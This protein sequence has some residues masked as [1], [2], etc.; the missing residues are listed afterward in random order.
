VTDNAGPWFLHW[1]VSPVILS[2]KRGAELPHS[3][4]DW[5]LELYVFWFSR[6]GHEHQPTISGM[7]IVFVEDFDNIPA[8]VPVPG[9]CLA[10][11]HEFPLMTL[12]QLLGIISVHDMIP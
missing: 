1:Y 7:A 8:E 2:G 12:I 4:I 10:L 11:F 9:E 6:L 5:H 3:H